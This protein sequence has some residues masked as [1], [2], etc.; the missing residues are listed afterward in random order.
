VVLFL[1]V[2]EESPWSALKDLDQVMVRSHD[3]CNF[4]YSNIIQYIADDQTMISEDRMF[5]KSGNFSCKFV[6]RFEEENCC[7]Q[8]AQ[9]G[10]YLFTQWNERNIS[11]LNS[12]RCLHSISIEIIN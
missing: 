7:K 10:F 5:V 3:P 9:F 2:L 4:Q 8:I 6:F 1:R 12:F 11:N